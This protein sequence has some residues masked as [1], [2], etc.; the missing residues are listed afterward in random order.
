[1]L[2]QCVIPLCHRPHFFPLSGNQDHCLDPSSPLPP[3]KIPFPASQSLSR[4][5]SLPY[6]NLLP[7]LF[8]RYYISGFPQTSMYSVSPLRPST[9]MSLKAFFIASP[10][11]ISLAYPLFVSLRMCS[12]RL[13]CLPLS[14]PLLKSCSGAG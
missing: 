5:T 8:L 10:P 4:S 11:F 6:R 3:R 2:A 9:Q 14:H 1:M 12:H 7:S 13:H